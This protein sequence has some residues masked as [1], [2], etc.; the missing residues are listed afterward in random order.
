MQSHFLPRPSSLF[1][2]LKM[3][4]NKEY[5]PLPSTRPIS[6]I[7]GCRYNY[8]ANQTR[9]LVTVQALQGHDCHGLNGH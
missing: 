7:P 1:I 3:L 2:K 6:K 9:I 5:H 4:I 8:Q